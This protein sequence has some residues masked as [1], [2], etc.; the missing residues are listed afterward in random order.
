MSEMPFSVEDQLRM[1]TWWKKQF[2][3]GKYIPLPVFEADMGVR[4]FVAFELVTIC[5]V[6]DTSPHGVVDTWYVLLQRRPNNDA[7]EEF[8]G[9]LCLTGTIP[10]GRKSFDDI[11]RILGGSEESGIKIDPEN[12]TNLGT[13]YGPF[14]PRGPW[15][16]IV[17]LHDLGNFDSPPAVTGAQEW[18]KIVDAAKSSE[19]LL[20]AQKILRHVQNYLANG[21]PFVFAYDES[22]SDVITN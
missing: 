22:T 20:S 5:C 18:W 8:R 1:I 17:K 21:K 6:V 3:A 12:L 14:K 19:V 10:M 2:A 4:P 11:L 13:V 16:G 9:R 7:N 15:T